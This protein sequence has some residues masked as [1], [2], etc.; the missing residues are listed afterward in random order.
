MLCSSLNVISHPV[1]SW[2]HGSVWTLSR[3]RGRVRFSASSDLRAADFRLRL[4][5]PVARLRNVRDRDRALGLGIAGAGSVSISIWNVR[6]LV[7]Q[8]LR[9][10]EGS[11]GRVG[12]APK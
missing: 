10:P 4:R 2:V 6:Y 1:R 3:G 5:R 12:W 11:E 7:D 9:T 8:G